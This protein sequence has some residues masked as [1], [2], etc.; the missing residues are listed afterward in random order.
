MTTDDVRLIDLFDLPER[1]WVECL[2]RKVRT[3]RHL[4]AR[5]GH[6]ADVPTAAHELF[7]DWLQ[8]QHPQDAQDGAV[9]IAEAVEWLTA[10]PR[11]AAC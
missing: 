4:L 7:L 9:C 11:G 3:L 8:W 6:P 10:E 2:R 1:V 5:L